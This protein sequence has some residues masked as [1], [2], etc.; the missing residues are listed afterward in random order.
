MPFPK[1]IRRAIAYRQ[2]EREAERH[3]KE[4]AA[5]AEQFAGLVCVD[6]PTGEH[7]WGETTNRCVLCG[8][9]KADG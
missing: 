2:D 5:A 7:L 8:E 4:M 9:V 6:S 1:H 3:A